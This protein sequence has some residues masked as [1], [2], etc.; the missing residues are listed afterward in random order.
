MNSRLSVNK[1][2][3]DRIVMTQVGMICG[4]TICFVLN[5]IFLIQTIILLSTTEFLSIVT[6][7]T[8]PAVQGLIVS[9]WILLV[10]PLFLRYLVIVVEKNTEMIRIKRFEATLMNLFQEKRQIYIQTTAEEYHLKADIVRKQIYNALDAG[11]LKGS[12]IRLGTEERFELAPNFQIEAKEQRRITLFREKIN[13]YLKTYRIVAIEKIAKAFELPQDTVEKE[14]RTLL[15]QKQIQGFIENENFVQ[16]LTP[17]IQQ[18]QTGQKLDP[19][20]FCGKENLPRA[21]FC[22][23]CGKNLVLEDDDLKIGLKNRR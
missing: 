13:Q 7:F 17:F 5:A 8:Q 16:D 12:F 18:L 20:P 23:Q 22:N 2:F 21:Q 3:S 9:A 10:W 14:L 1:I 11:L 4:E 15:E 19:C 6:V